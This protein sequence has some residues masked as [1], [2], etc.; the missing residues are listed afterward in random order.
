MKSVH[1]PFI[2]N[3]RRRLFFFG[4]ISVILLLVP[5]TFRP[6]SAQSSPFGNFLYL[7][8]LSR[9]SIA[10]PYPIFGV[11]IE[12]A[13]NT[14][15]GLPEAVQGGGYWVRFEAFDWDRIE[16]V[17][18]VPPTYHWETVDETSLRNASQNGLNLIA[19]GKIYPGLGPKIFGVDLRSD[20]ERGLWPVGGIFVFPGKSL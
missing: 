11:Q 8:L 16:P 3:R 5:G 6:A 14:G 7:P 19:H 17:P 2:G 10:T 15:S 13:I 4:F 1:K 20:K 12:G 9:D 18:S